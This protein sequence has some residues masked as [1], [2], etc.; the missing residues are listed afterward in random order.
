MNKYCVDIEETMKKVY[1]SFNEKDRRRYAA[2]EAKKLGFGGVTYISAILKCDTKTILKGLK[3]LKE[4]S[5]EKVVNIRKKGSGRKSCLEKIDNLN[6]VFLDVIKN[7]TAGSPMDENINWT[8]LTQKEISE[9]MKEKNVDISVTVVKQLL[10]K[11]GFV[12]RKA[13]KKLL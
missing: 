5:F 9:K 13:Q 10:K 1:D 3:E 2:V 12:K 7:N 11:H 4:K 6:E 8:N